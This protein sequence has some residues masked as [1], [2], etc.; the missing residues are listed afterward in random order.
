[1]RESVRDHLAQL[2][3]WTF[4]LALGVSAVET[5]RTR[6]LRPALVTALLC[7][8]LAYDAYEFVADE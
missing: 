8:A 5:L 3:H 2:D 4:L 1:M 6:R 7:V